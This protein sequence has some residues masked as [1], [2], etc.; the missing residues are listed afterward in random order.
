MKKMIDLIIGA[1]PNF[2]KVVK[3]NRLLRNHFNVR[4]IHTGQHYTKEMSD[5]FFQDL[6]IPEPDYV[7]DVG[8]GTH[9]VQT[10]KIMVEYEKLLLDKRND[11]T[12][13]FGDVNSTLAT[14][15][16]AKK[17]YIKVGHI[18]AGLRSFDK[19]MPEEINRMVTDTLSDYLFAPSVDG[20]N[21]LLNEGKNRKNIFLVG[22]IMIDTLVENMS[23]VKNINIE[24]E[25]KVKNFSYIYLTLHRPSNVD[26]KKRLLKIIKFLN[27]IAKKYPIIFPSHPRTLKMIE[28]FSLM[29]EIENGIKI[30]QPV[31]YLKSIALQMNSKFVITDSGGIQEETTFL[32]VLCFTLRKNTERP[33]TVLNGTNRLI[34]PD[35]SEVERIFNFKVKKPEKIKYWDGK[36]SERILKVIK[37]IL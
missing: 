30:I 23:F 8:S 16:T 2:I 25:F 27:V 17:L 22:N 10:G 36:T 12:L 32:N 33:I 9:A 6:K 14:T 4:L 35:I 19:T 34:E 21:N 24:K 26:D 18:E 1:R 5:I 13:V 3:L 31:S 20:V 37:N 7:F 15:I 11:L 29:N 28:K